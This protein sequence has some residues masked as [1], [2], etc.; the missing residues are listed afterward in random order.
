MMALKIKSGQRGRFKD[1]L[2]RRTRAFLT[3]IIDAIYRSLY[4]VLRLPRARSLYGTIG[5]E[6][7]GLETAQRTPL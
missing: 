7:A 3:G 4:S 1:W 2:C 6:T 5:Q